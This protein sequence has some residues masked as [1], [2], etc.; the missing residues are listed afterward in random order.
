ML[1]EV[2][3]EVKKNSISFADLPN[4]Y[5][6]GT[7]QTAEVVAF[8]ESIKFIQGLGIENIMEHI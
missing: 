1:N 8:N 4:K 6:A 7:M 2:V 5:E 3:V